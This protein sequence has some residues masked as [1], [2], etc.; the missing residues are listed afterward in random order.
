[1]ILAQIWEK[2]KFSCRTVEVG[3]YIRTDLFEFDSSSISTGEVVILFDC[4]RCLRSND[5]SLAETRRNFFFFDPV[6]Y[7]PFHLFLSRALYSW[8]LLSSR[9]HTTRVTLLVNS[10]ML[11]H[12][13]RLASNIKI[14]ECT[15]GTTSQHFV[16]CFTEL[17]DYRFTF[18]V[19]I[20]EII[21]SFHA[22]LPLDCYGFKAMNHPRRRTTVIIET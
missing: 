20:F 21:S 18:I 6:L 1:M 5:K 14:D 19:F 11:P 2:I 8:N 13:S 16:T 7:F 4:P 9:T 15:N 3:G 22:Y 17:G 12:S 10:E